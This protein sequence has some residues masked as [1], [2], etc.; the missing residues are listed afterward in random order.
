MYYTYVL[1]SVKD[2]KLYIGYTT[3]LRRRFAEHQQGRNDSTR[4]RRPFELLFYEAFK[5][6]R[7]AKRRESYFKTDKGKSTL[8]QM[9]RFSIE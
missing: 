7:D 1:R 4:N 9:L 2:R 5:D 3:D 8:R 6:E